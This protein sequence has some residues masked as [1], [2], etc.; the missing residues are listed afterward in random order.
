ME[1][2]TPNK[3][4][5]NTELKP[6]EEYT[7]KE[8]QQKLTD[9]GFPGAEVL[10]S[11]NQV[12]TVLNNFLAN[13]EAAKK[14][15]ED[16]EAKS[17]TAT[18]PAGDPMLTPPPADTAV[19]VKDEKTGKVIDPLAPTAEDRANERTDVKK[20]EGKAA[21]MKAHLAAQPKVS[22]L[23]PL[24]FGE[25]KG[26]YETVIMNGYRLNIMKGVMVEIPRQVA[27]L[28]AESYQLTAEAGQEFAVDR[29]DTVKEALG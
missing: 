22:F 5:E 26:A 6:L 9:L 15:I 29:T 28:L 3:T 10:T 8:L 1:D 20:W 2:K 19:Q 18:P 27:E 24:G 23:I 16:A 14:A 12:I 25:K 7:L 11:K 21:R 13:Q 4:P 17:A